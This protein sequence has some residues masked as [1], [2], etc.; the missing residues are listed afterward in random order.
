MGDVKIPDP[1][2]GDG[3]VEY[4]PA[5]ERTWI[6]QANPK[7]Y[8][9]DAAIASLS[10]MTW[11]VSAYRDLISP[12]DCVFLWKSG[13]EAGIIG[14]AVVLTAPA[15]GDP[16]GNE[17]EFAVDRER[18]SGAQ[19]RVRLRIDELFAPPLSRD[20]IRA[21]VRLADLSILKFSQ[22]TNFLVTSDQ[23]GVIRELL[24]THR[25]GE[26]E[27]PVATG[28]MVSETGSRVWAYAP[29]PKAQ[30]WEEFYREEI[31]AI[32]WDELG[33]IRQYQDH[34]TIANRL[35]KVY[36]LKG[37]PIND[38]RA[39]YNF[40]YLMKPGDRVIVKRGR[41]EVI[42]YGII[43]GEYEF[44]PERATYRNVRR[45]RWESRGNWKCRQVFAVKALTDF[46][47]YPDT[48]QY[49]MDLIGVSDAALAKEPART[50]PPFTVAD[51]L[52]GVA[53]EASEF[54]TIL[55]L[56]R[57]KKN[58]VI[59]GPP[60]VGK[61]FLARRLAYAL[62]GHELP[63]HVVMIQFHQS[64]AYEDFIQGFRPTENGFARKDGIFVRFCKRASL[65]QDSTYVFIID[66]INRSNLSKVLGELL[67]L[68]E[69][70]KRGSKNSV[71]LAYAE[72]DEE[73]FYVPPNVYL[74]GMMNTADRS[75]ALV[76]YALRRRFAF[77]ELQPLF[78]STAFTNH[79]IGRGG[80]VSIVRAISARLLEL[81]QAITQD[82]NL[83]S[84]FVI[85]HSYFCGNG[86]TLTERMYMDAIRH[87]ILPLLKEYWIDEPARLTHWQEKLTARIE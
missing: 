4:S 79:L 38:S 7:L 58:L 82:Q 46:T 3:E 64:Y 42:G 11:S 50:L 77:W 14:E 22:G 45:V 84:G 60:G 48:V 56:W 76:D 81:N 18:F 9:I 83:G 2:T 32:G 59:Q 51:A 40:L 85:G 35:I 86:L 26:D 65:D 27:I 39:C 17:N 10:E 62:I 74:L 16:I 30:F 34:N 6:F 68:I 71:A 75:L 61:T 70:D 53:F 66:E 49:L 21:D 15:V 87:E 5:P 29:G 24:E 44:R 28:A 19:L 78:G 36:D 23:A 72:S 55:G 57:I 69:A 67:M 31:M 20:A 41:D 80:H 37:Y 43:T 47:P 13:S 33:D 52:R 8:K 54:E 63:S 25:G 1:T 73:Q 12:G